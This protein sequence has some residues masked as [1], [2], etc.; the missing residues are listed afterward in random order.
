VY[1]HTPV[2]CPEW[3]NNTI[4]IDQGCVFGSWLT[5]L[6]W[7]ERETVRVRAHHAYYTA[8]TPDF[9]RDRL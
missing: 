5:A 7:P 2:P 1:G 6:R 3:R 9:V 4:N 8:R